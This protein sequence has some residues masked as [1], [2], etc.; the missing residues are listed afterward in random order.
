MEFNFENA[1]LILFRD[2]SAPFIPSSSALK[3]KI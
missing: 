1:K 3:Y 2:L